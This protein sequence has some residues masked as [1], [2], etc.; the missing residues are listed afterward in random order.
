MKLV[1]LIAAGALAL[2]TSSMAFADTGGQP[3]ANAYPDGT[4]T[5][6]RKALCVPP[7]S[8]FRT[9]AKDPSPNN[10]PFGNGKTPGTEV[11]DQ[12]NVG[13]PS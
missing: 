10:D 2:G 3:N 12:C 9:T 4:K 8:V 1:T 5:N 11:G 13:Q 6:G 7:G